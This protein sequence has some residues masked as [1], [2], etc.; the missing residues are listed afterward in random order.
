VDYG[1]SG[2]PPVSNGSRANWSDRNNG[3]L[4]AL[5]LEQ[6]RAGH[7][8]GCQMSGEGY[9]AIADGYFAKTG[10]LH[11]RLQL[12]NQIGILKS[13]YS[14]WCY[15]QIHTGLGRNPDGSVDADSE[16]W[17]PHLEGKPY[18]KRV[19]RGPPANLDQ[20]EEMFRGNT[21][22][23]STVFVPGDDYGEEQEGAE[24]AWPEEADEDNVPTP[25]SSSS[26]KSKRSLGSLTSTYDS[27]VK[28]SKS[29]MV[30]YVKDI[31]NTFKEAA[32]ITRRHIQ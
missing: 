1:S 6:V 5:C 20:L 15:L 23:G 29:R 24:D 9:Q 19:L 27:L 21:M 10:L 3:Y 8:N 28:K 11:T 22:D 16:Y 7:Y 25:R 12:K 31:A 30:R 18:L 2:V 32:L 4:L 26:Q 13:T 14:F 17:K